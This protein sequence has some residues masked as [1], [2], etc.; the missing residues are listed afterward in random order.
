MSFVRSQ[1][2][3]VQLQQKLAADLRQAALLGALAHFGGVGR[4]HAPIL[5]TVLLILRP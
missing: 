3:E 1:C 5:L 4:Q 2:L